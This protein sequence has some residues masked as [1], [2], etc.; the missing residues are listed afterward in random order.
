M[1]CP[2]VAE[3]RVARLPFLVIGEPCEFT[4]SALPTEASGLELLQQLVLSP[5]PSLVVAAVVNFLR[6]I[7]S[8]TGTEITLSGAG[9]QPFQ[10]LWLH[11]HGYSDGASSAMTIS[12]YITM[13]AGFILLALWLRNTFTLGDWVIWVGVLFGV[14]GAVNGLRDSM[15]ALERLSRKDKKDPPPPVSFNNHD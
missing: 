9:G 4:P 11:R 8:M 2:D 7:S 12:G 13:Q 14:V 15:R 10:I 1:V 5:T 3:V 6:L